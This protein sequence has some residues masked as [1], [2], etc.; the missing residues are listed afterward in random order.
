MNATL[1]NTGDRAVENL[2][3]NWQS[4]HSNI[5]PQETQF[6]VGDLAA[7]E[8]AT[9]TFGVDVSD[10]ADAGPRQFEFVAVYRDGDGDRHESDSLVG[11]ATVADATDEFDVSVDNGTV[12]AG[13]SSTI[14]V[15]VTNTGDEQVTDVSAK[16]FADAPISVSD[17]EAF[18]SSLAPGESTTLRFSISASGGAL[19]K[20]YPLSLDFRY[21]EP[22]GDTPVSDTYRVPIRVSSESGGGVPLTAV[23]GLVIVGLLAV[24]GY[25][26]YQ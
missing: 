7:G 22:D 20:A 18:V 25:S 1:T 15:I 26:R 6:A 13:G 2:V 19:T 14:D 12:T 24:G 8:S 9:V 16:L 4:D 11:Q 21:E 17:D 10:S 3:V 5:S 23:G